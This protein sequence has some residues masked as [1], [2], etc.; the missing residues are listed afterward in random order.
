MTAVGTI[1]PE[2]KRNPLQGVLGNRNRSR[3]SLRKP[4]RRRA[5]FQM[6][7][8][9]G[10]P[11]LLNSQQILCKDQVAGTADGQKFR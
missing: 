9:Q 11:R 5:G 1:L 3:K 6:K 4:R 2:G 10:Y 8:F 7:H